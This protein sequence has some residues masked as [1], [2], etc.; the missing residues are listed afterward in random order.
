MPYGIT[1]AV[2]PMKSKSPHPQGG[3]TECGE[4]FTKIPLPANLEMFK[5]PNN[6][7]SGKHANSFCALYSA[8]IPSLK[9]NLYSHILFAAGKIFVSKIWKINSTSNFCTW[10]ANCRICW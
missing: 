1:T 7:R 10:S 8:K 5:W 6:R 3:S 2:T 9:R 4:I